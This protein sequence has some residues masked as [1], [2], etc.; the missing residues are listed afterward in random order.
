[1]AGL[2]LQPERH[3]GVVLGHH[4]VEETFGL[5]REALP[6]RVAAY[7]P[8]TFVGLLGVSAQTQLPHDAV[9]GLPDIVLHGS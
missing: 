3:T 1:M 6:A 4:L 9:E 8:A 2:R 7:V 5:H